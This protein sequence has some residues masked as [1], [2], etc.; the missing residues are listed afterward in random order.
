MFRADE[1]K[2]FDLPQYFAKLDCATAWFR[3]N[4]PLIE[5]EE[6]EETDYSDLF[7]ELV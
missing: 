2:D 7:E 1:I 4:L 3:G 6:L 5:V